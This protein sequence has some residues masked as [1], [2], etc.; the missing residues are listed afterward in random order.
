MKRI[1][2]SLF[3]I[4]TIV[5]CSS[6]SSDKGLVAGEWSDLIDSELSQWDQYLSY[7]HQP[8]YYGAV[9]KDEEGNDIPPIGMNTPGYD[10][11]TTIQ[12]GDETIIRVSG[13]YYGAIITK[14]EYQN[15]HLQLKYKWGELK[16]GYRKDLLLDSGIMYHSIGESG[17]DYW[18]SWMLS[19]EFQIMEGH[20]GDFWSQMTSSAQVRAYKSEGKITPLAHADQDYQL[21]TQFGGQGGYCMR[22]SNYENAHDEWNRL[23]LYCFEGKSL[24]VVNGE[25]VM[26][27][28]ESN[29]VDDKGQT[30]PLVKG[31]IQLQSEAAEIF[32]KDIKI[33]ELQ[34]LSDAQKSLF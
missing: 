21:F 15:Y 3:V 19:Q 31:K 20:T 17:V 26:I 9:P 8:G 6:T 12:D 28:K 7:M 10:V 23:D 2:G 24:H 22:S 30:Q 5:A 18:R 34:S 16:W 32:F 33:R 25:V 11:F 13:E 1:V 29:Y 14:S 4:L 27:L